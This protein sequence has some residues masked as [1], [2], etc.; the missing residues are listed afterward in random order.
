M[1][2]LRKSTVSKKKV[3]LPKGVRAVVYSYLPLD[4]LIKYVSK[5]SKTDRDILIYSE[6]LD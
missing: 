6:I 5:L 3:L 1:Q 2:S 4:H